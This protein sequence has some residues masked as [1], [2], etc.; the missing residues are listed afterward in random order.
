MADVAPGCSVGARTSGNWYGR[1]GD[2]AGFEG[3]SEGAPSIEQRGCI[4]AQAV[5]LRGYGGTWGDW[6]GCGRTGFLIESTLDKSILYF[7]LRIRRL[8]VRIPSGAQDH[9]GSD[10]RKH[11]SGPFAF[12]SLVDVW[13]LGWCSCDEH[14]LRPALSGGVHSIRTRFDPGWVGVAGC[15]DVETW[16]RM[17]RLCGWPG[18]VLIGYGDVAL[19]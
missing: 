2:P 4:G 11:G 18:L 10:L 15:P 8:G 3:R 14:P 17:C 7:G 19:R 12:S 13:V 1:T 9:Q 6:A 16:V 5:D